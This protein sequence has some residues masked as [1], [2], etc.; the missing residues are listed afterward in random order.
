MISGRTTEGASAS[1]E[2]RMAKICGNEHRGTSACTRPAA[3]R[4][5]VALA[6]GAAALALTPPFAR[7]A[8]PS[9]TK[10]PAPE[11]LWRSY[12]LDSAHAGRVRHAPQPAHPRPRPAPV[13][14]H[15]TSG[16]SVAAW[17]AATLGALAVLVG[18]VF[19]AW[20]SARVRATLERAATR[21]RAAWLGSGRRVVQRTR[22]VATNLA[23]DTR[24][25]TAPAPASVAPSIQ[26]H[27][28]PTKTPR[29]DKQ[30][31]ARSGVVQPLKTTRAKPKPDD[32][33][34]REVSVLKAK[35]E[36]TV[37]RPKPAP[38]ARAAVAPSA[39]KERATCEVD[40][41]RGYVKSQFYA[42]LRDGSGRE[43]ILLTS[44]TFRWSKAAPPPQT[45]PDVANAHAALIAQ[46]KADGWVPT[47][48]GTHWYAL[49]LQRRRVPETAGAE[50]TS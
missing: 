8:G 34:R 1:D 13:A 30:A 40:L 46:L 50:R 27:P 49:Q 9:T 35:R 38:A 24:G 33:R 29:V 21:L 4:L 25:G 17:I 31:T 39:A 48:R 19:L 42:A 22:A 11:R 44:P 36:A 37:D 16:S 41:W 47:R 3:R 43:S 26:Q 15:S 6:L 7:A 5:L 45:S 12:P 23:V 32:E 20:R 2:V 18:A 14:A 28:E 10:P